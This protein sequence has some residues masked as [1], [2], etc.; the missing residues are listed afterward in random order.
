MK[1]FTAKPIGLYDDENNVIPTDAVS[2]SDEQYLLLMDGQRNG[3]FIQA[4]SAGSP[5]LVD[6]LSLTHSEQ[7]DIARSQRAA[8]LTAANNAIAPLQDSIDLD[9]ATDDERAL[10]LIWKKYRVLLNRIDTSAAPDIEWPTPPAEQ[11]S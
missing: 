1:Y 11:A 7:V 5:E 2:I 8:L 3:K 6:E 9:M 10:L 4:D